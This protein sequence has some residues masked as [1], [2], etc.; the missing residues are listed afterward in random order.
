[1]RTTPISII[2]PAL[3]E[4]GRITDLL[5]RLQP[6]R[7]RGHEVILVD[8]GSHDATVT[9]AAGLTD[10]IIAA[11]CG[12]ARQMAAGAA[13]ASHTVLWLLHA[14]TRV[15]DHADALIASA[16]QG[17]T[18]G[19]FDVRLSGRHRQPLL[20][21]VGWLINRRSRLTG[22]ATGDQGIFV[23]RQAL[24]TVGGIPQLPLM[25]DVE[26]SRRLRRLGRPACIAEPLVTSS[27]RW[28]QHGVWRTIALMWL[29]RGGYALG[30]S[31]L[32]LARLYQ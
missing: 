27:R 19:R 3:N 15:P 13:Q 12:R 11:P 28:E 31:P 17:S 21:V 14:D 1:M 26:L 25:E 23:S 29:L 24:D 20:R 30:V 22:I 2:I 16:L 18:W 32:R 4:A 7:E 5:A 10:R 9:A 8:G 6:L